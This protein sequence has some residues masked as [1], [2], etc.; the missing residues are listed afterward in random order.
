MADIQRNEAYFASHVDNVEIDRLIVTARFRDPHVRDGLRR[1][2]IRAGHKAIDVGCGPLGALL[3][4]AET[5]GPT[6]TVVGLDMDAPSL[7][8]AGAILRHHGHDRVQLVQGNIS[9]MS[10]AAIC[11]PGPF[12]VAVCT[13]FLNNQQDPVDAL[14]RVAGFVRSGGH[15][16]VQSPL[17]FDHAPRSEPEVPALGTIVRWFGEL[18]R[19]RGASPDV[20]RTYRGLCQ[21]AGLKEVSQRG[22]FLAESTGAGACLQAAHDA[23]LGISA[24]IVQHSIASREEVDDTLRQLQTSAACEFQVYFAGMHVELIA[25]VP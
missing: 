13:Q 8:Q 12:D 1:I 24:Q 17:F 9:A 18:M 23:L 25:Q 2:G 16:L 7:Q 6:G 22:F 5:I 10:P 15:L 19:R 3:V 11:P 21:A 4:L 14:R 20:A